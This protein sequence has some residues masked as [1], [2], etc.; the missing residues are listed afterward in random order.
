MA[1]AQT[2]LRNF[3]GAQAALQNPLAKN[4]YNTS[5]MEPPREQGRRIHKAEV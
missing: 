1:A 5:V 4:N 2:S 3:L